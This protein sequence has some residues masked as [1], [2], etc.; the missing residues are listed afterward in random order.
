MRAAA[1]GGMTAA[2][3]GRTALV[4]GASRGIGRAIARKLAAAG[5]DVGVGFFNARA[6]AESVCAEIR[7]LGRRAV[8]LRGN[9]GDPDSVADLTRVFTAAL[10][11][12]DILISNAASGVLRP[13]A[14]LNRKHWRWCLEINALAFHLLL[15]HVA[16]AMRDGARVVALSSLGAR[17]AI[18][19]YAF[20]GAS[21]AALESLVR[22]WAAELAP[23]RI[24]VNAV[25]AGVVE[26]E[27]LDAF[28]HK[29]EILAEFA[30][31]APAGRALRADEV[32]NAV[33]LLCLPDATMLTG[34][35]IV[36]DGAYTNA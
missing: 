26:T 7:S 14:E 5:C 16:P 12:A 22:S 33:Y 20:V 35:T 13:L 31:R 1:R 18:P 15:Q 21:K 17:R 23:R 3:E 34:Q 8:A 10:G 9:V 19:D 36:V 4:T 28:P 32:A 6:E 30:R 25:S 24:A 11:P 2:L 29:E 27:A